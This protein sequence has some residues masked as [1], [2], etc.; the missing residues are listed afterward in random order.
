VETASVTAE[1]AV[2]KQISKYPHMKLTR[3]IVA[4]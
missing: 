2:C 3:V 1:I 4:P